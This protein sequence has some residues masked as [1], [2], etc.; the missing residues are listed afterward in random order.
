VTDTTRDQIY[1]ERLERLIRSVSELGADAALISN[2]AL[3]SALSG[4][5]LETGDI[6]PARNP[7]LLI[8]TDGSVA[9]LVNEFEVSLATKRCGA[10]PMQMIT[11][12]GNQS[13]R[14]AALEWITRGSYSRLA[15]DL[16]QV[17]AHEA[18]G[19]SAA[20]VD[21]MDVASRMDAVARPKS[22]SETAFINRA[23]EAL[24]AAV[25]QACRHPSPAGTRESAVA[26]WIA[27]SIYASD[28]AWY[29]VVPILSSGE[30]LRVPHAR[31]S[32]RRLAR[33]DLCRIGARGRFGP[34]HVM[35]VRTAMV[36]SGHMEL[37]A[38]E[39]SDL[40]QA[41]ERTVNRLH[42]RVAGDTLE[43]SQPTGSL[44]RVPVPAVQGMGF[45]FKEPPTLQ[46]GSADRL[47]PGDTVLISTIL[48]QPAGA[49][50]YW[51]Q[52]AAVGPQQLRLLGT[53]VG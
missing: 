28:E 38:D 53:T 17:S 49:R 16:A 34:F 7:W 51:Q 36:G 4:I 19:L 50:L 10:G 46:V 12:Q 31:P 9:V 11:Y 13:R 6:M 45:D 22:A 44:K 39:L 5:W 32:S 37:L 14:Q 42:T 33:G 24:S 48:E 20:A 21:L 35:Y 26:G 43:L 52:M 15:V 8:G 1:P 18:R 3:I 40:A 47:E 30:N 27:D 25:T 2:P 41:H 29:A 23:A